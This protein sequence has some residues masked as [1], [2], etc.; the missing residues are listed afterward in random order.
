MLFKVVT[1]RTPQMEAVRNAMN[2]AAGYAM[3]DSIYEFKQPIGEERLLAILPAMRSTHYQS[4]RVDKAFANVQLTLDQAFGSG[5]R[6][7]T[8]RYGY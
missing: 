1:T 5:S 8:F 3:Y 4:K 2:E 7:V 6:I